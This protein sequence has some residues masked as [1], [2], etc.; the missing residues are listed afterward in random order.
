MT[1]MSAEIIYDPDADLYYI[2]EDEIRYE[3]PFGTL[4]DAERYL[5]QESSPLTTTLGWAAVGLLAL[6]GLYVYTRRKKK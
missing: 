2:V 4:G 5:S 6:Y 1:L 3:I